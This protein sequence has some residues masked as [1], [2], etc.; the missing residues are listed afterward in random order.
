MQPVVAHLYREYYHRANR[1]DD[2][3]DYQRDIVE[4]YALHH[5]KYAS[6]AKGEE[7]GHGNAVGVAGADGDNSLR[8][9]P[10]NHAKA[11]RVTHYRDKQFHNIH[12]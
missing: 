5:E 6:Q 10:Q 11:R 1:G 9:I 2:I 3:G 7:C 4:T 8:Q 12:F